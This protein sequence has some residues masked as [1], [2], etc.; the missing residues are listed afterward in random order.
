MSLIF[1]KSCEYATQ[2]VL[3]IAKNSSQ[4]PILSRDISVAL[5][6][7]PHFLSKVLQ[8]LVRD[9]IIDSHKG[10]NGGYSLGRSAKMITIHDIVRSIDGEKLLDHCVLG[11]PGCGD[12]HP[13]PVHP[14]WALA[15]QKILDMLDKRTVA[16]LSGA[17]D[18]KLHIITQHKKG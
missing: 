3:F 12:H 15:K 8:V 6:I 7:P 14:Q 1:S 2:A 5:E 13:C 10:A 18:I 11:F 17:L 4:V 16:E 9:G